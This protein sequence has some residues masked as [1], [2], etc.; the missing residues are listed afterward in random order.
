[1][2]ELQAFDDE[3]K[4]AEAI[5]WEA[6]FEQVAGTVDAPIDY[7]HLRMIV[8]EH[9]N[10]HPGTIIHEGI[11]DG[12]LFR[13]NIRL[14]DIKRTYLFLRQEEVE[15]DIEKDGFQIDLDD[16]R[17][18][19]DTIECPLTYALCKSD[20]VDYLMQEREFEL[21]SAS[22]L[23]REFVERVVDYLYCCIGF[24]GWKDRP[25]LEY[26]PRSS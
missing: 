13:V 25:V 2:Q 19:D 14:R 15:D 12:D 7:E 11:C 3:M 18:W 5:D 20:L 16:T 22:G 10:G 23:P 4:E 26:T 9:L 8:S 21:E 17:L 1:M 6:L 24:T